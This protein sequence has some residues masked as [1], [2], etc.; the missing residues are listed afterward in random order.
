M[1]FKAAF[2]DKKDEKNDFNLK[3]VNKEPKKE[4]PKGIYFW[5]KIFFSIS[6]S[7]SK[8]STNTEKLNSE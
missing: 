2:H 4:K 6:V 5:I 1:L 7:E 3:K 8:F